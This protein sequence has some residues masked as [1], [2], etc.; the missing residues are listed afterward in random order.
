M[1]FDFFVYK[2]KIAYLCTRNMRMTKTKKIL[3]F[4]FVAL[5]MGYYANTVFFSHSHVISG[6]SIYHS[7]IH[8][9]SHHDTKSGNHTEQC[10]TLIAQISNYHYIDFSYNYVLKPSQFSLLEIKIVTTTHWITSIHLENTSLR[11][12]PVLV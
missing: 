11:A 6:A 7:H 12:P 9:N 4:L 8:P 1:E 2:L 10:I 3:S 5:F